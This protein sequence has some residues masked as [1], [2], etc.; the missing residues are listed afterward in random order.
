MSVLNIVKFP[1]PVLKEKAEP[2]V[3]IDE[4]VQALIDDMIETIL[5]DEKS[6]G[7]AANQVGV[8]RRL[9]VVELQRYDENR[10]EDEEEKVRE[11]TAIINP[12]IVSSEG[13]I[14]YE[15]GCLS[16]PGLHF[17]VKRAEAVKVTGLDREGN[18]IELDLNGFGAV[19]LQ[20]E[21]DHLDGILFIDRVSWVKRDLI[22][23]K[24]KR[25]MQEREDEN[26]PA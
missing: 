17:D 21:I 15:E 13:E 6:V 23:R 9:I 16:F 7:L 11:I 1:A 3:E 24:Y 18:A 4:D 26:K 8:T 12:E 20:H 22:K 19:L 2:I 25:M 10:N 5:A 14:I